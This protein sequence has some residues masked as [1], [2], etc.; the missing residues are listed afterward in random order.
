MTAF[1]WPNGV[2]GS[3]DLNPSGTWLVSQDPELKTWFDA[4]GLG[5]I[6]FDTYKV[7]RVGP[8]VVIHRHSRPLR[9][10]AGTHEIAR[11]FPKVVR[12]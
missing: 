4:R 3:T 2:W 12:A 8:F 6:Y 7:R 10:Y 11:R 9:V 1:P 5:D